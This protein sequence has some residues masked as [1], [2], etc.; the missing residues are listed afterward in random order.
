MGS[1]SSFEKVGENESPGFAL[2]FF[3]NFDDVTMH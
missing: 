1:L 3:C 2:F